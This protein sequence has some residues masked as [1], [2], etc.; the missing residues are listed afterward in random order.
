MK[1]TINQLKA[2]L[3]LL[4]WTTDDLARQSGVSAST[5]RHACMRDGTFDAR[6]ATID[7]IAQALHRAGV[8]LKDGGVHRR[9]RA[10]AH[11]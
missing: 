6:Q 2:A 11:R 1:F 7:A 8:E 5:I 4:A 9:E 3:T 10:G